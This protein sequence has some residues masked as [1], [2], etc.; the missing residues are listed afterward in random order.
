MIQLDKQLGAHTD[1]A[2]NVSY[3]TQAVL[4]PNTFFLNPSLKIDW[5]ANTCTVDDAVYYLDKSVLKSSAQASIPSKTEWLN[6]YGNS[7]V[8]EFYDFRDDGKNPS[9]NHDN[10]YRQK[11]IDS[12]DRIKYIFEYAWDSAD[13]NV[14]IRS[15][16][17][18]G[19]EAQKEKVLVLLKYFNGNLII[20]TE[21][22]EKGTT[23]YIKPLP[24]EGKK[25]FTCWQNKGMGLPRNEEGN[26]IIVM[27]EDKDVVA[28]WN[29]YHKLTLF[30]NDTVVSSEDHI[31]N[32][33]VDLPILADH[34]DAYF[35]GWR[36]ATGNFQNSPLLITDDIT[37]YS[38]YHDWVT[39]DLI[40]TDGQT[41]NYHDG[42]V[43]EG[44]VISLNELNALIAVPEYEKDD[45]RY[46][47]EGWFVGDMSVTA[48]IVVENAPIE[49]TARWIVSPITTEEE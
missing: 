31:E 2:G 14:S 1:P 26:F 11:Y 28:V 35:V 3:N 15:L 12:K 40:S 5:D 32:S 45:M 21:K 6:N 41:L 47:F 36:L 37:L 46:T 10:I 4:L 25:K 29:I 34:T 38:A 13:N 39:V 17:P 16:A 22:I 24:D 20:N 48:D 43:K 33:S 19:A 30:D 8:T 44:E 23:T 18:E 9:N 42:K 49:L 7:I 27:D